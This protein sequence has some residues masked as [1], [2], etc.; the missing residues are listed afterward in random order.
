[1]SSPTILE[2]VL[3]VRSGHGFVVV[4][5]TTFQPTEPVTLKEILGLLDVHTIPDINTIQSSGVFQTDVGHAGVNF[6]QEFRTFQINMD[7]ADQEHLSVMQTVEESNLATIDIVGPE[8]FGIVI[9][10]GSLKHTFR[11]FGDVLLINNHAGKEIVK[12]SGDILAPGQRKKHASFSQLI[13]EVRQLILAAAARNEV[14]REV[15]FEEVRYSFS[16]PFFLFGHFN[17]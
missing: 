7:L 17:F 14:P 9:G 16:F 8:K 11:K 15:V 3:N 12:I 2:Q 10:E 13:P 6:I 1:M 5:S 4:A